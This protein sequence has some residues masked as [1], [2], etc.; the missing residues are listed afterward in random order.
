MKNIF[1]GLTSRLDT[2]EERIRTFGDISI[3]TSQTEKQKLK[4]E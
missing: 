4:K 1:E 2:A 3:K